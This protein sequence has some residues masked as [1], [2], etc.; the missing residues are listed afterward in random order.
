MNEFLFKSILN[1]TIWNHYILLNKPDTKAKDG[2]KIHMNLSV[3]NRKTSP[4]AKDVFSLKRISG[5]QTGSKD[6]TPER[7]APRKFKREFLE[8]FKK[9]PLKKKYSKMCQNI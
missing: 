2:F 5:T 3:E 9:I 7:H 1:W 8:P 6:Y 4:T